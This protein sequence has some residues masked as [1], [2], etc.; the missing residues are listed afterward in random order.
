MEYK[1]FKNELKNR[2][3]TEVLT[4]SQLGNLKKFLRDLDYTKEE[5]FSIFDPRKIL[6]EE[7]WNKIPS[8]W[9]WGESE[10]AFSWGIL[11]HFLIQVYGLD[12]FIS[13]IANDLNIKFDRTIS[14]G[15]S[16]AVLKRIL[17]IKLS[18]AG[19]T[20][21]YELRKKI[22]KYEKLV[23]Y[24][25]EW[26]KNYDFKFKIVIMGLSHEQSSEFLPKPAYSELKDSRSALGVQFSLKTIEISDKR[27]QLQLWDI[28]SEK[29]YKSLI[30]LATD[31][32]YIYWISADANG[33]LIA[34]DKSDRESFNLAKESFIELKKATNLKFEVKEKKDIYIDIPIILVGLGN[35]KNVT[36]EDGQTLAKEIGAY[37][38]V[39]ISDI[40][41]QNFEN[42]F[43]TLSLGIITNYKNASKRY[44]RRYKRYRFK[45]A[46]VGDVKV[47]KTSL[48]KRYTKGS[49]NKDYIKTIGAQFSVYDREV[50]G[51][52]VRLMFWDIAGS[53]EF[54]FLHQ[55]FMKKSRA[56]IIVYSLGEDDQEKDNFTQI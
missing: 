36:T 10:Q 17:D 16:E 11:F 33:V 52:R 51:D 25:G 35:E 53:K 3:K 49:Y 13:Q 20:Q 22:R 48:I 15:Q 30:H 56:A 37:D 7:E 1:D 29:Q 46:V 21:I 2:E 4:E 39:E 45:I 42:I 5:L 19:R 24:F 23:S 8:D 40:N 55:G 41:I 47:G 9:N 38:Y 50:E 14:Q 26:A 43:S 28:S 54:H 32:S 12:L 6:K 44:I 31:N 34:F 27:V 18:G